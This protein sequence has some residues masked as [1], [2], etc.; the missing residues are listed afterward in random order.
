M[1]NG[2]AEGGLERLQ[3]GQKELTMK[4]LEKKYAKELVAAEPHEKEKIYR[5]I[6]EEFSRQKSHKPSPAALW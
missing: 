3:C 4:S 2:I 5:R 1:K 6:E